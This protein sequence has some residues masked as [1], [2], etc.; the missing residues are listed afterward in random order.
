MVRGCL[1]RS[2][3]LEDDNK[4]LPDKRSKTLVAS[5]V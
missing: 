5:Q 1:P 3:G 2:F 4:I